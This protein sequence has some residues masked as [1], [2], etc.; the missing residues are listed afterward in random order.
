MSIMILQDEAVGRNL[1]TFFDGKGYASR[2]DEKNDIGERNAVPRQ[3]A[4]HRKHDEAERREHHQN[5]I[6]DDRSDQVVPV[7]GSRFLF[8]DVR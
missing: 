2:G 3:D 8:V 1:Y 7:T 6:G 4:K 5:R